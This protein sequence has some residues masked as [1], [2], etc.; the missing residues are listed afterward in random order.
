MDLHILLSILLF[1][2]YVSL[3]YTPSSFLAA[4]CIDPYTYANVAR[5]VQYFRVQARLC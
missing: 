3:I 2:C 1:I 5:R 4:I